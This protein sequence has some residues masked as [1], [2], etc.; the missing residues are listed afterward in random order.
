MAKGS[1]Q[2]PQA[3]QI[4]VLEVI[5]SSFRLEPGSSIGLSSPRG[6]TNLSNAFEKHEVFE[7]LHEPC[8]RQLQPEVPSADDRVR[9]VIF[10]VRPR[11]AL[12]SVNHDVSCNLFEI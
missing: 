6:A 10:L 11:E 7:T 9:V 4:M 1:L 3:N 5:D 12:Q 2:H 8:H